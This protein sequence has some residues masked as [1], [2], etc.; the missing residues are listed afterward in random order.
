MDT[1]VPSLALSPLPCLDLERVGVWK[2]LKVTQRIV[3]D[4]ADTD[5]FWRLR[6]GI[7]NLMWSLSVCCIL[8]THFE[9]LRRTQYHLLNCHW[10]Q[11]NTF[12]L[13]GKELSFG[14]KKKKGNKHTSVF[15]CQLSKEKKYLS[16]FTLVRR[17]T[18]LGSFAHLRTSTL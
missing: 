3:F 4:A 1:A 11:C 6:L 13:N 8:I 10:N 16:V 17:L 18:L 15:P 14:K 7:V 2:K 5:T 9:A 12:L